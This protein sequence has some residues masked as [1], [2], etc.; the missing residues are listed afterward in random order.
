LLIAEAAAGA[1]GRCRRVLIDKRDLDQL[2][3]K[4]FIS[5]SILGIKGE[6]ERNS[7]LAP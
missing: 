3:E 6:V 2:I 4:N 5:I 7:V 1:Q